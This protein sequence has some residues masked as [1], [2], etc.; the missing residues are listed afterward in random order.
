MKSLALFLALAALNFVVNAQEKEGITITVTI[1]NVTSDQGEV[2][3]GLYDENTFMKAAPIQSKISKITDG[4]AKVTFKNIPAGTYGI[5]CFHDANSNQKMDFE[6]NGMPKESYGVSNNPMSYGPPQWTEAQFE[7]ATED[8][9]IEIRIR[10][11]GI[12][13][14]P[15]DLG[16]IFEL[17]WTSKDEQGK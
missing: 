9:A 14:K 7:V 17:G 8:L 6:T 2:M 10:D 5:T 3:V 1:P 4:I 15:D 11:N 13:I 12:G 16:Q